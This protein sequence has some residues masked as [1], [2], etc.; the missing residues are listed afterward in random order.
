M[1][2]TSHVLGV[3]IMALRVVILN[4]PVSLFVPSPPPPRP[5]CLTLFIFITAQGVR[6]HDVLKKSWLYS[7][8]APIINSSPPLLVPNWIHVYYS[9]TSRTSTST[10]S[11]T[12]AAA[13][14]HLFFKDLLV[15]MS[16]IVSHRVDTISSSI[17]EI[18][19]QVHDLRTS[20]LM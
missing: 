5:H 15:D 1:L 4:F 11:R 20:G 9:R 7:S 16:N 12:Q 13:I 6:P 17:R 18:N 14:A 19:T 2:M 8:P 10:S 3:D